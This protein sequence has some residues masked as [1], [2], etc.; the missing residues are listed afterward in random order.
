MFCGCGTRYDALHQ[1][2]CYGKTEGEEGKGEDYRSSLADNYED[3]IK[4]AKTNNIAI[5]NKTVISV[6]LSIKLIPI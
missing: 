6:K 3:D 1:R 4:N 2:R 5:L